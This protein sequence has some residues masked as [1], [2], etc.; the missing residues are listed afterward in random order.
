MEE[1]IK[2]LIEKLGERFKGITSDGEKTY[3]YLNDK[4]VEITEIEFKDMSVDEII[5]RL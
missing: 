2:N 3:V 5:A 1:K 4:A